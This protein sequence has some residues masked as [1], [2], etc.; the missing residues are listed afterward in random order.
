MLNLLPIF[1]L[2]F[3]FSIIFPLFKLTV[4]IYVWNGSLNDRLSRIM[5]WVHRFGKWSLLDVFVVAILVVTIKL[6]QLA[7]MQI[8]Y[9]L[10]LFLGSVIASMFFSALSAWLI[11]ENA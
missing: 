5:Q 1:L 2:I 3:L 9:G 10:Y 4:I 7:N 11:K 6:D 8:Q